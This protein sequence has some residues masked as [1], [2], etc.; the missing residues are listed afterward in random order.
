MKQFALHIHQYLKCV[1]QK[2]FLF[3]SYHRFSSPL[4]AR[5]VVQWYNI[6]IS[7]IGK[8]MGT[9]IENMGTYS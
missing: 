6:Y 2:V 4:L 8:L 3:V 5:N 1:M 9:I 7:D